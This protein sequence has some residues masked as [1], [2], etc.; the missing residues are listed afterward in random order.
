[1]Q[2]RARTL[3]DRLYG[4]VGVVSDPARDAQG[5]CLAHCPIAKSDA[6]DLAPDQ[7]V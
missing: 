5:L 7:Q 6:L 2:V 3:G 1:L 4:P